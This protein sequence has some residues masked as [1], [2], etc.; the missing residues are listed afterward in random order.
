MNVAKGKSENKSE[1]WGGQG[2]PSDISSEQFVC[3]G[4]PMQG[5]CPRVNALG[6]LVT[7]FSFFAVVYKYIRNRSL[8]KRH[9]G[10]H[11]LLLS[12]HPAMRLENQLG[13]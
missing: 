6:P 5:P 2:S 10:S 12:V 8:I 11:G 3:T 9:L 1:V 7:S 4:M 13:G